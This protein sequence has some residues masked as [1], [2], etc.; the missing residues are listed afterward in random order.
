MARQFF[1][2]EVCDLEEDTNV[3]KIRQ[4]IEE[5]LNAHYTYSKI[6]VI[7]LPE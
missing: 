2:V 5:V 3:E 1:M 4:E 6:E 7:T